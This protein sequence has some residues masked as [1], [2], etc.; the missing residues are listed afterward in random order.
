MDQKICGGL[1]MNS[2]MEGN[3]MYDDWFQMG[4]DIASNQHINENTLCPECG[5]K[6]VEYM[7]VV[8]PKTDIGYMCIWCEACMQGIQMSRV[9][10]PRN[11]K[12]VDMFD[13]N[14]VNKTIPN[15]KLIHP[16][17]E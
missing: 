6:A 16:N 5:E 1:I 9:S 13:K 10:A 7:Y 11:V 4:V 17:M 15:Y 3:R 14:R 8:D 12:K 2:T